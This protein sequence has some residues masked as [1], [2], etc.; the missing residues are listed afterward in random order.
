[1]TYTLS[2]TLLVEFLVEIASGLGPLGCDCS[3]SEGDTALDGIEET[4][5][6]K[7][8]QHRKFHGDMFHVVYES[9]F[10]HFVQKLEVV[11]EEISFC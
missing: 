1:M 6:L 4:A 8:A 9:M 7:A 2:V 5:L 10:V 11:R 3:A